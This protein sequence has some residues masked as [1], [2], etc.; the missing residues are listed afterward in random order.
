MNIED[1]R[2]DDFTFVIRYAYRFVGYDPERLRDRR[3][4]GVRECLRGGGERECR[5]G[6]VFDRDLER[7]VFISVFI[8][9]SFFLAY[10]KIKCNQCTLNRSVSSCVVAYQRVIAVDRV[11]GHVSLEYVDLGSSMLIAHFC[12]SY[13]FRLSLFRSKI[14]IK[15]NKTKTKIKVGGRNGAHT[16]LSTIG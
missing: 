12:L 4:G 15:S 3:S 14:Q 8:F 10:R 7:F 2:R 5:R 13:T 9:Q 1:T 16:T 11:I 6:G